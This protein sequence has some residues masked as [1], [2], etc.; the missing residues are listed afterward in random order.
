MC[1]LFHCLVTLTKFFPCCSSS[2][3]MHRAGHVINQHPS[4]NAM[5][6]VRET[7]LRGNKATM[8]GTPQKPKGRTDLLSI[9][10]HE[11]LPAPC[12]IHWVDISNIDIVEVHS[13]DDLPQRAQ[14][15]TLAS[16]VERSHS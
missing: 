10:L 12:S 8:K 3:E 13:C 16:K 4:Q 14:Q 5:L 1:Q 6:P 15:G 7:R 9:S 2:Y 11:K